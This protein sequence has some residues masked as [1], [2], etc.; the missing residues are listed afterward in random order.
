MHILNKR[1]FLSGYAYFE[2]PPG[3]LFPK[4][5]DCSPS[6][7]PNCPV[8]VHNNWIVS[9]NAKVYRFR[10]HLMWL[11]DGDDRY[12]SSETR[13]YLT[14]TNPKEVSKGRQLSALISALALGRM[15]NRV[16]I[17]PRFL[18][19]AVPVH[20][21]PLNS[22]IRISTFDT[23][24]KGQFRESSFLRHPKVPDAVKLGI[25]DGTKELNLNSTAN[26]QLSSRK[27]I[28]LFGNITG[29]VLN[30]GYL[31]GVQ[32]TFDNKLENKTFNDNVEKAIQRA[33]YRQHPD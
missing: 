27:L 10:E 7:S 13:N 33:E 12:Y 14:Y 18:C 2:A 11:Y 23:Y 22:L 3:R 16:V 29:R 24:F 6:R 20:D 8:V 15:L 4:E 9:K 19:T 30:V 1:T 17:L 28:Q 26:K 5:K 32:I 21:C 31:F 25:H